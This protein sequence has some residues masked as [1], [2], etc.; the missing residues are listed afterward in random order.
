MQRL[1]QSTNVIH[2]FGHEKSHFHP[3][4]LIIERP[5]ESYLPLL[6][7]DCEPG[8]DEDISQEEEDHCNKGY[9]DEESMEESKTFF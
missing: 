1:Q 9:G 5:S 4:R 3:N 8:G 6:L 2:R 7:F